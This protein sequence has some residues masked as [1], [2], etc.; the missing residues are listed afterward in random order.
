M[1]KITEVQT[2]VLRFPEAQKANSD[3]QHRF[4][5]RAGVA[6]RLRTDVGVTGHGYAYFG[7]SAPSADAVKAVV[8]QQLTPVLLGQDPFLPRRLRDQMW[9]ELEY[10]GIEGIAH[11]ALTAVDTALWDIMARALQVPG[12]H[13]LGACRDKIPAY[14]M[15]GW[16]YDDDDTLERY[17]AAITTAMEDGMGGVKIK[18]GRSTLEEDVQRIEVAQRI[19]GK[20]NVLMVDANQ[21]LNR[22]EALRRGLVYQEL[23][24]YW[25]E[26]P[27]RPHD[28][29]GYGALCRDLELPVATGENEYTK[30]H[31]QELITAGGCDILQPDA[32]RTGG[33]SEWMEIAGL[34]AA[35]HVPIA[36]HGGDGVA[37]HLLMATPSAI[38]C[39]TGGVPKG[40]GQFTDHARIADGHVY[41]PE[42]VGFGMELRE[43]I[44]ERYGVKG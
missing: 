1:V 32:R 4:Y 2:I 3:A 10:T 31:V 40:P 25:F 12:W 27:L 35:H 13:L 24:V 41:A 5:R 26:E 36:S 34:A 15:V 7:V 23:G 11:F 6:I 14:A 42:A 16:Y 18:V 21:V 28:K 38:W 30:Y 44:L 22:V 20:G 29:A 19:V 33:P 39:E 17:K 9:H 8:D 43:E 37:T